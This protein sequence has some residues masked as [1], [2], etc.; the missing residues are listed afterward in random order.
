MRDV[1]RHLRTRYVHRS[2]QPQPELHQPSFRHDRSAGPG[3]RRLL[4]PLHARH[5]HVAPGGEAL[6]LLAVTRYLGVV[7][8][9]RDHR[10]LWPLG[11][12]PATNHL[13]CDCQLLP[14]EPHNSRHHPG[15]RGAD[16]RGELQA[17][18]EQHPGVQEQV[19]AGG[20][21]REWAAGGH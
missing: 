7:G 4:G 8:P 6:G 9:R 18:S 13:L 14:T 15:L 17:G 21:T 20:S 1:H 2:L 19:E 16:Q 11:V 5:R 12:H 10:W 3:H